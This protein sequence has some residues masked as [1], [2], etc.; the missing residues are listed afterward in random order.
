MALALDGGFELAAGAFSAS[1]ERSRAAGAELGLARE[2]TY[3]SF[4][5]MAEAEAGSDSERR[6]DLAVI[7]TPNHLHTA[8]AAAFLERGVAVAC[9]KPLATRLEDAEKLVKLAA[10]RRRYGD[11]APDPTSPGARS[12]PLGMVTYNYSGYPMVKEARALVRTGRIG[13]VRKVIVEYVQGWLANLLE[14]PENAGEP[15]FK[16]AEWRSDP[17][18]GGP[19]PVLGDIGTHAHHL[20]RYVTGLE[21]ERI[22]AKLS[23]QVPGRLVHDDATVLLELAGGATGLLHASQVATGERNHLRIRVYGSEGGIDWRQETPEELSLLKPDGSTTVLHR[24]AGAT[25]PAA[26]RASRLPGGHPEGF[27]EGF[28]NLY[29]AFGADLRRDRTAPENSSPDER[30]SDEETDYPTFEDGAA[31]VRFVERAV[32]SAESGKWVDAGAVF[33]DGPTDRS[34]DTSRDSP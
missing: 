8:A 25:S 34:P 20:L 7:V 30:R 32:E 3:A 4:T 11:P 22:F 21:P 24:A 28:A 10:G 1:S 29:A 12:L 13:E 27:I 23:A 2:R 15:G 16:Q 19:S 17:T 14:A 31:G 9:D 6:I 26:G 33:P 18:R 5:E